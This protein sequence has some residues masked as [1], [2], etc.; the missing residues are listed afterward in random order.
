MSI[1][2]CNMIKEWIID[3]EESLCHD[4]SLVL[5]EIFVI[6]FFIALFFGILI[7]TAYYGNQIFD[8]YLNL[9]L[10][11]TNAFKKDRYSNDIKIH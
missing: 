1:N 10:L 4:A 5:F 11:K 7:I 6:Y 9:S 2:K 3:A 8:Q